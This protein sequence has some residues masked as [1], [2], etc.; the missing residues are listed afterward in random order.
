MATKKFMMTLMLLSSVFCFGYAQSS[1]QPSTGW[2]RLIRVK[3]PQKHRSLSNEFIEYT[4][5]GNGFS[6]LPTGIYETLSVTVTNMD[7][8]S[9]SWS[10]T[11]SDSEG[12]SIETGALTS[13]AYSISVTTET[14]VVFYGEHCF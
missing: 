8:T 14:G 11:L 9:E 1:S 12:Y 2:G 7:N 6:F 10:A 3:T 13:G 5:T 4:Y